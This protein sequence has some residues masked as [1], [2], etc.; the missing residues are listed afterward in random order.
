[1]FSLSSFYGII[2]YSEKPLCLLGFLFDDTF[3]NWALYERGVD[4][5]TAPLSEPYSLP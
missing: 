3:L 2:S 5:K 4:F 1:M